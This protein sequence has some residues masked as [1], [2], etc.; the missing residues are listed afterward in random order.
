MEFHLKR[1]G[2]CVLSNF[3]RDNFSQRKHKL[4][5][6]QE[7]R[8]RSHGQNKRH[9]APIPSHA[10]LRYFGTCVNKEL[11]ELVPVYVCVWTW[12]LQDKNAAGAWFGVKTTSG[13]GS[14]GIERSSVCFCL[15][16]LIAWAAILCFVTISDMALWFVRRITNPV[17]TSLLSW[18]TSGACPRSW[19]GTTARD[20]FA[21]LTKRTC[22]LF[23][24]PQRYHKRYK[25]G[26][27]FWVTSV[28]TA[29]KLLHLR[30]VHSWQHIYNRNRYSPILYMLFD[31]LLWT[32]IIA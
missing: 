3:F 17:E 28:S 20:I 14:S 27:I 24:P 6:T 26:I 22:L 2:C 4:W 1:R 12:K 10:K 30:K 5:R 29:A 15:L 19:S 25:R 11:L 23:T 9:K 8:V 7:M 21:H 31:L 13:A 32:W 16:F 18:T